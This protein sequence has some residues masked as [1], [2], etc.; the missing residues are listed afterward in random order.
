[1]VVRLGDCSIP[2]LPVTRFTTLPEFVV[3]IRDLE[4]R[5][6]A[7]AGA[8]LDLHTKANDVMAPD[9]EVFAL[10]ADEEAIAGQT[11]RSKTEVGTVVGDCVAVVG[12]VLTKKRKP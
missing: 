2:A 4:S 6:G 1:M 3:R 7:P 11:I 8:R 5:L 12:S 10:K 9:A